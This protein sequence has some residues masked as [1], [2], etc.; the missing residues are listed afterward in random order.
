MTLFLASG[1]KEAVV[2]I[3]L[4]LW[5]ISALVGWAAGATR[6]RPTTGFFLGLCLGVFGI[7][8]AL[9]LPRPYQPRSRN[10]DRW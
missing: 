7:L 1:G 5:A 3:W 9:F 8:I 10:D 4:I 2:S 6:G